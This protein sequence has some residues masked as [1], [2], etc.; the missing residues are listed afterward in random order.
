MGNW[1]APWPTLGSHEH[2]PM[3]S[4]GFPPWD[5]M[6]SPPGAPGPYL[7]LPF[8]NDFYNFYNLA[9]N[10]KTRGQWVPKGPLWDPMV[11]PHGIPWVAPMG[12]HGSPPWDPMGPPLGPGGPILYHF[13]L[14][15]L[16][17]TSKYIIF[18]VFWR[19]LY[20]TCHF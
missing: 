2:P 20:Q 11:P 13:I 10:I 14:I 5:P 9:K 7:N 15:L 17:F 6:G 3:G 4:H 8:F 1:H 16:I 12:S 18:H 19:S